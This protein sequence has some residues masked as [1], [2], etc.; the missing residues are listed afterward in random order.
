MNDDRE[1]DEVLAQGQRPT[2]VHDPCDEERQPDEDQDPSHDHPGDQ[3]D[4]RGA[5]HD[6]RE[7][8]ERRH[9]PRAAP[10]D[11]HLLGQRRQAQGVVAGDPAEAPRDDIDQPRSTKLLVRVEIGPEQQPDAS[12]IEQAGHHG[13]EDGGGDTGGL[14][15]HRRPVGEVERVDGPESPEV[16]RGERPEEPEAFSGRLEGG[17]GDQHPDRERCEAQGQHDG[18][19]ERSLHEPRREQQEDTEGERRTPANQLEIVLVSLERRELEFNARRHPKASLEQEPPRPGE[20]ATDDRVGDESRQ[21]PEPE[22]TEQQEGQP[23]QER[24]DQGRGDD[25]EERPID[26]SVRVERGAGRHDRQDRDGRVLDAADHPASAGPPRHDRERQTGGHQV[27]ADPRRQ[28]LFDVAAEDERGERD[29]EDHFD[30]ADDRTS[31][32]RG[33]YPAGS[34]SLHRGPPCCNPSGRRRAPYASRQRSARG[35]RFR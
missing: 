4:G 6:R 34:P 2:H 25:G 22:R 15:E 13:D 9:E 31:G 7:G 8:D 26:A 28:E 33:Q 3:P 23:G 11:V 16:G 17:A 24:H 19:H 18:D 1:N 20:E 29:R 21:V 10:A 14:V 27:D 32:D 12:H 5:E 35:G 30:D